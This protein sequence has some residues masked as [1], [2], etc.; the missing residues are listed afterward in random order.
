MQIKAL[1]AL[2][3]SN[4]CAAANSAKY[5]LFYDTTW[6][7][8][9]RFADN[10]NTSSNTTGFTIAEATLVMPHL[11]IPKKPHKKAKQYTAS[12]WI[13]LDGYLSSEIVRGLWQAGVIMS[14]WPNGT[15]EYTGFHEWIPDDPISI[16][17]AKL[18]ISEGDHVH[19]VLKTTN[20]GYH[21]STSLTNLNTSQTYT[22]SQDAPTH[23]RGP[24][25]PAQG[26]SAEWI[27]EAGT[28]LNGPQYIFPDWGTASFLNARACNK[29]GQ[30]VFPGG[31]KKQG[32]MT[33]VLW[34]DTKTLYTRSCV[35][36]DHVSI[37]YV[38]ER[39]IPKRQHEQDEQL[40]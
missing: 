25:F 39:F 9:V 29:N 30:C 36:K 17:F 4:A 3:L 33:A 40:E 37:E 8:P 32:S 16:S 24:T 31:S 22:H 15:T 38:E 10:Y 11:S 21:G 23:W 2:F 14:V 34:N 19:V 12:Y 35:E 6:A 27:V 26:A 7:G 20:N 13:G 18:A 28:Y 1:A 5:P